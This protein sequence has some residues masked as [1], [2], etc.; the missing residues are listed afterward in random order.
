MRWCHKPRA[1]YLNGQETEE[2]IKA[3]FL[4]LIREKDIDDITISDITRK[5]C[6]DRTTFYHHFLRIDDLVASLAQE[7]VWE[8][9]KVILKTGKSA[10]TAFPHVVRWL[11]TELSESP[12]REITQSKYWCKMCER[13]EE[14]Y[15]IFCSADK[16]LMQHPEM[17][18]RIMAQVLFLLGGTLS[19]LAAM[20]GERF[21]GEEEDLIALLMEEATQLE[22]DV[23]E[24]CE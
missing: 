21:Q 2:N 16:R 9:S 13:I 12:C 4:E 15:L 8:I 18:S 19:S 6:I 20:V 14:A 24:L 10:I 23:Q 3:A 7:M 22:L 17:E 11:E 5:A 1:Q